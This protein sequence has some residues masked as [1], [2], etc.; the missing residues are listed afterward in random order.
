MNT[1]KPIRDF[2]GQA[3]ERSI[4]YAEAE[5]IVHFYRE[6]DRSA[7]IDRVWSNISILYEFG[8]HISYLLWSMRWHTNNPLDCGFASR[9]S[10]SEKSSLRNR[11]RLLRSFSGDMSRYSCIRFLISLYMYELTGIS[12]GWKVMANIWA[13][14]PFNLPAFQDTSEFKITNARMVP[15]LP[16]WIILIMLLSQ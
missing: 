5:R 11:G 3:I 4:V 9:K 12:G 13:V 16:K 8:Y 7:S 1:W 15:V 14:E 6:K 10:S 2:I